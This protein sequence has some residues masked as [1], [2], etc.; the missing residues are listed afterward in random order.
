M[1]RYRWLCN[2]DELLNYTNNTKIRRSKMS[3]FLKG[4]MVLMLITIVC[5]TFIATKSKDRY[6]L[7]D[8]NYMFDKWEG[9][10][11]LKNK[12]IDNDGYWSLVHEVD[13]NDK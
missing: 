11:F 12:L 3:E 6:V 1:E 10:L 4:L 5:L 7:F 2:V 8:K 13:P 9:K